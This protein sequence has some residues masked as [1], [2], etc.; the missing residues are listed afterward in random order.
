VELQHLIISESDGEDLSLEHKRHPVTGKTYEVR[1]LI[2]NEKQFASI[3]LQL[4]DLRL[5]ASACEIL[6][7]E[8]MSEKLWG[9]KK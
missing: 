9:D 6:A 8:W 7:D 5:L 2:T 3:G 1:L 4:V